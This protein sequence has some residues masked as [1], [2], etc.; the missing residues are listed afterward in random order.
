MYRIWNSTVPAAIVLACAASLAADEA[1][2]KILIIKAD[3]EDE[4]HSFIA[5]ALV[6]SRRGGDYDVT[7]ADAEYLATQPLAGFATIFLNDVKQLTDEQHAAL[8]KTTSAGAGLCFLLGE[9]VDIEHYNKKLYA[10]GKGLLPLPLGK[11]TEMPQGRAGISAA[12]H[13]VLKVFEGDAEAMLDIV[14]VN[15]CHTPADGWNAEDVKSISVIAKSKSGNPIA[16]SK[17]H[18]DGNT[19]V[20]MFPPDRRWA[21]W[22]FY[23]AWVVMMHELQSFMTEY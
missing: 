8:K 10:E 14:L 19:V 21:N 9:K 18:G 7:V 3:A 20:F 2:P 13:P 6:P 22:H 15:K 23:P 11:P 1:K 16:L 4:S 17:P 12:K 5:R